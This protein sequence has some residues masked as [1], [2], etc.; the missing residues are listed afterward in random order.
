LNDNKNNQQKQEIGLDVM[1]GRNSSST[2]AQSL[3]RYLLLYLKT[4]TKILNHIVLGI[5]ITISFLATFYKEI[6]FGFGF[7]DIIGYMILYIG[8]I[9][10]FILTITS[11][12][13]GLNRHI[14]LVSIFL[15]FTI[16]LSLKATIW[17]GQEYRWNGNIFYLPCA[18]NIKV[19]NAELQKNLL[20]QKC[21]MEYDSEFSGFWDGQKIL[22]KDGQI[23]I[24][25]DLEK[26]I[27]VPISSIEIEP[28]LYEKFENDTVIKK[29]WFNK[30]T[31]KENEIYNFRGEIVEIRNKIPVI[32]V[33][34]NNSR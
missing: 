20:V 18:T 25:K 29:F 24:P 19:D 28:E 21:S 4:T 32:K 34:I 8:T 14:F 11:R 9:M 26:Y 27:K 17:R 6:S 3:F 23:K 1:G 13:K 33:I 15:P 5:L 22:F 7:R 2:P 31:L 30:D 10:H 12:N 16:L